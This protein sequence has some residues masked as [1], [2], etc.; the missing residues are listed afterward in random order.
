MGALEVMT[1]STKTH[2]VILL[3]THTQT[4]AL[5]HS[6]APLDIPMFFMEE[7]GSHLEIPRDH[8]WMSQGTHKADSYLLYF[9]SGLP[10]LLRNKFTETY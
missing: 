10:L 5:R 8:S 2:T 1:S 4:H 9:N 7:V 6:H 3:L